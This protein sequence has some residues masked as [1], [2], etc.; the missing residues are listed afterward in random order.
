MPVHVK[1]IGAKTPDL[2]DIKD[3]SGIY[4]EA[5]TVFFIGREKD[6][7]GLPSQQSKLW[8]VKNRKSGI[9]VSATFDYVF[10]RYYYN[11]NADSN[12]INKLDIDENS[13]LKSFELNNR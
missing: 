4:Q 5:D 6:E 3:S 10:G 7:D 8:L 12:K 9:A 1:K 2:D 13:A 11:A